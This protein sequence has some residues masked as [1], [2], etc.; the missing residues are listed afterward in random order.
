[1]RELNYFNELICANERGSDDA[2]EGRDKDDSQRNRCRGFPAWNPAL[3]N[4]YCRGYNSE[5]A[6]RTWMETT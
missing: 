6:A 4:A 3:W 1:M 5:M 2:R